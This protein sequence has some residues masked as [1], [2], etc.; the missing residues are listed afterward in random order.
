MQQS[1]I[2]LT[3]YAD[4]ITNLTLF[5]LMSYA[6]TRM[7]EAKRADI[8]SQLTGFVSKDAAM[9]DRAQ[10]ILKQIQ[11]QEAVSKLDSEKDKL[12]KY[13]KL[14]VNDKMI[15]ILLTSPVLFNPGDATLKQETTLALD[16]IA[17]SLKSLPNQIVIEGH[18]DNIPISQGKYTTNWGLS[19]AR[20]VSV[21]DYLTKVKNLPPEKFIVAG[22]GEFRPLYPNDTPENR[23]QNRRIEI[24]V[25][26]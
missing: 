13:A 17:R 19:I 4:I 2:W 20:A 14:E 8:Q 15:R 26:K 18:T 24:N 25:I 16:E 9:S 21:V 22:Y 1:S 11:E 5:F 6:F 12:D 3:I 10:R 7:S 23:A